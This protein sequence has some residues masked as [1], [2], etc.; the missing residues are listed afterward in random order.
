[1]LWLS[2]ALGRRLRR[3]A[4]AGLDGVALA[5]IRSTQSATGIL[6]VVVDLRFPRRADQPVAAV[7]PVS[8]YE[9]LVKFVS[10]PDLRISRRPGLDAARPDR[11]AALAVPRL[12]SPPGN[13]AAVRAD[14]APSICLV[15]GNHELYKKKDFPHWLGLSILTFACVGFLVTNALYQQ[16]WTW[17]I[18]IGSAVFDGLLYLWVGD[19]VVCYRCNAHYRGVT[20]LPEHQPFELIIGERYRQERIRREQL[21]QPR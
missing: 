7:R 15:C 20:P 11:A 17:A 2:G 4:A 6:Y 18:L 9:E 16:W 3:P 19:A 1:M 5:R 12:R 21:K 8:H 13:P 10:L 14:T